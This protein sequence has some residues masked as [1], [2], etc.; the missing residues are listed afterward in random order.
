MRECME[1]AEE[2]PFNPSMANAEVKGQANID[3]GFSSGWG[4]Q[5]GFPV[6]LAKWLTRH[7]QGAQRS[8]WYKE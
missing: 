1:R 2:G 4:N 3:M 7:A 6:Q 5:R 8:T